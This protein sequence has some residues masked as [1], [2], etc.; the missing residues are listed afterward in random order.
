MS[1]SLVSKRYF[2]VLL[3]LFSV[4]M[5]L[6]EKNLYALENNSSI[7]KSQ[8]RVASGFAI[9]LGV[10]P[11]EMT[12]GLAEM[13]GGVPTGTFR[14]HLTIA[15]FD[16]ATG[17]RVTD[18]RVS[19]RMTNTSS[20]KAFKNLD[21]MELANKPVYGNYFKPVSPGPYRIQVRVEH[22]KLKK[23][24]TVEFQYQLAHASLKY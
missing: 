4:L 21:S 1:M 24:V 19:A 5:F 12:L 13:H 17:K 9:Y 8:I 14:Y 22:I 6:S 2:S 23:P 18:A 3:V 10:L 15:I 11:A 7:G 16:K 20:D